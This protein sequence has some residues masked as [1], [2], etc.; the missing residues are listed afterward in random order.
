SNQDTNAE[1][2]VFAEAIAS[3]QGNSKTKKFKSP[4][5]AQLIPYITLLGTYLTFYLF[6]VTKMLSECVKI[7]NRSKEKTIV[8]RYDIPAEIDPYLL[9]DTMLVQE[10]RQHIFQCYE[11]FKK[12]VVSDM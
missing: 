3:F 5:E 2:Q 12:F 6:K 11:A 10:Y 4:L 7:E 8:K 9:R 1:S